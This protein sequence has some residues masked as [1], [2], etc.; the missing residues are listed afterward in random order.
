MQ[1]R[2]GDGYIKY[3]LRIGIAAVHKLL[4]SHISVQSLINIEMLLKPQTYSPLRKYVCHG[5]Q[6]GG[7]C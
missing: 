2:G 1:Q 6:E 4:S 5:G 3:Q 7:A